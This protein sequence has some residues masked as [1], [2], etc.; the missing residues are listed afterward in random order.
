MFLRGLVVSLRGLVYLFFCLIK[1][2]LSYNF[3]I[4]LSK[5]INYHLGYNYAQECENDEEECTSTDSDDSEDP[6]FMT[7]KQTDQCYAP[8]EDRI[9]DFSSKG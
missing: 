5:S 4:L 3:N 7:D 6:E 2:D 8:Y 1:K 9:F